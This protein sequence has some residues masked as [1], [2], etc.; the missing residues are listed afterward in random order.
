MEVETLDCGQGYMPYHTLIDG[1]IVFQ[2]RLQPQVASDI[3]RTI[4]ILNYVVSGDVLR[5]LPE[6]GI[7]LGPLFPRD[8]NMPWVEP[9]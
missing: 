5:K 4:L 9:T 6:L 7:L 2:R 1:P 8:I 3:K